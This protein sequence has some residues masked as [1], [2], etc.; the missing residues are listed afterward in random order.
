MESLTEQWRSYFEAECR[1]DLETVTQNFP[2]TRSITV[3]LIELHSVNQQLAQ[4]VLDH[5]DRS[6][7]EARAVL[8]DLVDVSGPIQLRVKNN[9]H[10]CAV[11]DIAAHQLHELLTVQGAVE[12]VETPQVSAVTAYYLCPVCNASLSMSP[13]GIERTEPTR[14]AECNWDGNFNFQPTHSEFVDTQRFTIGPSSD[15]HTDSAHP[16]SLPVYVHSDLVGQVME[17][18]H[19]AVTG[20]LRVRHQTETP[21][22]TLYL[23]GCSI[24]QERD[25]SPPESLEAALDSQWKT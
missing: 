13:A 16:K 1:T 17:G 4:T 20:I 11:A 21:L 10:Q 23:D 25:L 24:R 3:D 19:I 8:R 22:S 6:L 15:Q 12:T 7:S 18:D 5:P 9:P 14:C 2:S